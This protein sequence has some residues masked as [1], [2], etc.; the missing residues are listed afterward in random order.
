MFRRLFKSIRH[1]TTPTVSRAHEHRQPP[2]SPSGRCNKSHKLGRVLRPLRTLRHWLV[3]SSCAGAQAAHDTTPLPS[4]TTLSIPDRTFVPSLQGIRRPPIRDALLDIVGTGATLGSAIGS[5]S[6]IPM[7]GVPFQVVSAILN[8]AQNA[9]SNKEDSLALVNEVSSYTNM[10]AQTRGSEL[11]DQTLYDLQDLQ[12][13]LDRS[14]SLLQGVSSQALPARLFYHQRNKDN[15]LQCKDRLT[16][17]VQRIA[18]QHQISA[19]A[20]TSNATQ[21]FQI[22]NNTDHAQILDAVQEARHSVLY[23]VTGTGALVVLFFF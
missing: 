5:M 14:K 10:L 13:Q 18:L 7:L 20:Q 2:P 1:R 11:T 17:A 16:T 9:R 4:A 19:H 21:Q 22:S 8:V 12:D 15:I 6:P 23:T 3:H